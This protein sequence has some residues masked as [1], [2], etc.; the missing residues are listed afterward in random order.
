MAKYDAKALRNIAV[1]GH[2]GTG[3]TTLCET[4]LYGAGRTERLGR[5]DE[6]T[7]VMDFEPEEQ[8]RHISISA[9]ANYIE[10]D[11]HKINLLDTPGDANFAFEMCSCLRVVDGVLIL[12]DAVEGAEFQTEKVWEYADAFSLPRI[13]FV[14]RMD[15]ERADFAKALDSVKV[16]LG[17]KA[18]A[19]VLPIGTE[20]SFHGVIDLIE[21]KALIFDDPKGGYHRED[22]P[23]DLQQEAASLREAMVE[24]IAESDEELMEKYLNE[25]ELSQQE[26]RAG[27]RTA[28]MAGSIVPALCGAA[29]KNIGVMPLLDVIVGC[30]PSPADRGVVKGVQPGTEEAQE[31]APDESAPF[32]ALVF[33][34]IADP[35]TGRLTIFR[36]YSGTLA[37]DSSFYNASRRTMER[38]GNIFFLEGKSQKPV[39][40]PLVPGDIAAVAKLKDTFTGDTLC[41]E[42]AQIVYPWLEPPHPIMAYAVEPRSRGD[43]EKIISAL[44]RLTEEDPALNFYRDEQTKEMILAGMGQVHIEATVEK[45]K[46][47]FG[48]EVN[49]KLPKVPY[50]ETIKGKANVQGRYKK[51]SGGRGQFGDCWIDIEPLP[52]GAGF[53]FVDKIVGGVIPQ[54]YRPAVEKGIIEAMAEGALAGYPIV[55]VKVSL[56]DGSYH[57]VDSSELAFKIAG[58]LAF[59][60]GVLAAQPTLL[61]PIVDI[62]IEIPEEYMGD[63]IGDL[64]SRRGKVLG[65]DSKGSHRIIRGQVPLAEILKYAADLISMTSGRGTFTYQFSHYEEVPAYIA[66]KLIAEAKQEK[67]AEK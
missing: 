28:V 54:Q 40:A 19:L 38:F 67:E 11:K 56:V 66:E 13:I 24:D 57:T 51:Q 35:Y 7:A 31:R 9:A 60:K 10:W 20:D 50:K 15:R 2:G 39:E 55:D 12:I 59:K 17:V 29:L 27:L 63:V 53:E 46:R 37:P 52:R 44:T 42:K 36:V 18:T 64:N 3:K 47:K 22:V 4:L 26:L 65:M 62:V 25:G 5:V 23:A 6:G 14:N 61:E 45:M 30:M 21:M 58:S 43:E 41:A 16:K 48:V 32:S 8:R 33:K 49:L 1:A 34:T